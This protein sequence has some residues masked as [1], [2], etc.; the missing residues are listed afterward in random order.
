LPPASVGFLLDLLFDPED[1][2]LRNTLNP[3]LI[4]SNWEGKEVIRISEA[5]G[6]LKR[7]KKK[8]KTQING[9][10]NDISSAYKNK[11]NI[12]VQPLFKNYKKSIYLFIDR[13]LRS[14]TCF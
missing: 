13:R 1:M 12:T 4:R 7:Q 8:L 5:K 6:S 3:S 9:K 11:Q 2:F 10:F 14:C